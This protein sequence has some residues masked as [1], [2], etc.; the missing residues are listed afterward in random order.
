VI[1]TVVFIAGSAASGLA[2]ADWWLIVAR[3]VQGFGAAAFFSAYRRIIE[4]VNAGDF[5]A[6]DALFATDMVDHNPVPG[7]VPDLVGFKQWMATAQR[8]FPDLRGTAGHV[9]AEGELVTGRVT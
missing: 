7:Q 3:V 8:S 6:L 1:G 4:A 9:L 2:Q 5:D